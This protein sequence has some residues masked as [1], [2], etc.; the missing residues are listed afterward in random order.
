MSAVDTWNVA[1]AV[2]TSVGGGGVIVLG[3]S[4]WLGKVWADRLMQRETHR[5]AA[6]LEQ[7]RDQLRRTSET[8]L[9]QLRRSLDVGVQ[10]HLREVAEKVTIY[11]AVVDLIAEVLG[12]F[13]LATRVGAASGTTAQRLDQFNRQR[14]KAYG[15][16]AMLA[17]QPVMD[18]FDALADHLLQV[19][20]G[21]AEYHWPH[22]RTLAIA[23]L[24]EVRKDIGLDK[25]PIQY[26]G[27]VDG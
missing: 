10:T 20:N 21:A 13:D 8:E 26:K 17:P 23:L 24:N 18:A 7:L 19:A 3:L 27:E 14:M 2:L 12:D 11:R 6:Q 22:V 5:H 16:M 4:S 9:E 1:A 25:S 15:W